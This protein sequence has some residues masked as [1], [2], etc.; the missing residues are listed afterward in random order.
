[1]DLYSL[2]RFSSL[3]LQ[4]LAWHINVPVNSGWE[5]DDPAQTDICIE[6]FF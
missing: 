3:L 1:M 4:G 5:T 2:V 6:A